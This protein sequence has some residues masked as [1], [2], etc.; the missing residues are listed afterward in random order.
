VRECTNL[1][2]HCSEVNVLITDLE[3]W[4]LQQQNET[5]GVNRASL[6]LQPI[7][8]QMDRKPVVKPYRKAVPDV[9]TIKVYIHGHLR[10]ILRSN[11]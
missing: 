4:R 3:D 7:Q 5:N 11:S 1:C 2:G 6:P 8:K 10:G 9:E